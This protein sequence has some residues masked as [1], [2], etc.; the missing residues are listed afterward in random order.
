MKANLKQ[1]DQLILEAMRDANLLE[2][3]TKKGGV[4][5]KKKTSGTTKNLGLDMGELVSIL[6]GG[7][8]SGTE[9]KSSQAAAET[10]MKT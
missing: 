1:L 3:K 5:A 9:L 4:E 8:E 10:L 2:K 7:T 6:V